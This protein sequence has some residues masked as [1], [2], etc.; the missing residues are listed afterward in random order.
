MVESFVET[1]LH[2]DKVTIFTSNESRETTRATNKIIKMLK[3]QNIEH[4]VVCVSE[5]HDKDSLQ[6]ALSLHTGFYQ[7]PNVYFGQKHIGGYDD[8]FSH[9]SCQD[10]LNILLEEVT[11][12]SSSDDNESQ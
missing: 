8:L 4:E 1:Y 2:E 5:H 10:A 3:I 12:L 11:N 9:F 6:C 7:Y